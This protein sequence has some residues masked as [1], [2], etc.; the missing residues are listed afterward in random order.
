MLST[1][2]H[3]FVA[4]APRAAGGDM[5]RSNPQVTRDVLDELLWDDRINPDNVKVTDSGEGSRC[6]KPSGR[7]QRNKKPSGP[8]RP[9][10]GV[11]S[12][13]DQLVISA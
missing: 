1:D 4:R 6:A 5:T 10:P 9:A 2:I 3:V 13:D 7:T 8:R 11:V 12:V